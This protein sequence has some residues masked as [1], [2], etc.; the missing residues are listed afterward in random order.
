MADHFVDVL[1]AQLP[2]LPLLP[3]LA[4]LAIGGQRLGLQLLG[5]QGIKLL[6]GILLLERRVGGLQHLLQRLPI[7]CGGLHLRLSLH[8]ADDLRHHGQDLTD[9]LVDIL[10]TELALL[11]VT[12][13]ALGM[14]VLL[15]LGQ[16]L[17][18]EWYDLLHHLAD[19]LLGQLPLLPP[20]LLR[21]PSLG[22]LALVR[23]VGAEGLLALLSHAPL[24]RLSEGGLPQTALSQTALSQIGLSQIGLS[25]IGL[26]QIGQPQ[27]VLAKA[28]L[29]SLSEIL[30][31]LRIGERPL[32]GDLVLSFGELH[33]VSPSVELA[34][35]C[36]PA[37]SRRCGLLDVGVDLNFLDRN[38]SLLW[39][40]IQ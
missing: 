37:W 1:L 19:I 3:L 4:L 2:L 30:G 40:Y 9:H 17:R 16:D 20:S 39:R 6:E 31:V 28:G 38:T 23:L 22:R 35:T 11:G 27:G 21:C 12:E 32:L 36:I 33:G 25:Q 34:R 14:L 18:Q 15:G 10:L 26:S 29:A 24:L 5:A 7:D 13:G 8:R